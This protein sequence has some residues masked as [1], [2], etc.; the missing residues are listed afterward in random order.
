MHSEEEYDDFLDFDEFCEDFTAP[1]KR[2]FPDKRILIIFALILLVLCSAAGIAGYQI[3]YRSIYG[4][5]YA[6][7]YEEGND[8]GYNEGLELGKKDGYDIGYDEGG[9]AAKNDLYYGIY[10]GENTYAGNDAAVGNAAIGGGEVVYL[11]ASGTC[12]H[13][14]GCSYVSGK[15]NLR[16][17]SESEAIAAGY[18][19]C[20]RCAK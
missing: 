5:G 18:S 6:E 13:Y 8:A 12:Y 11:T 19:S 4:E 9:E 2:K 1:K 3:G 17:M 20:S 10:G 15:S 16:A 7:G 14:E